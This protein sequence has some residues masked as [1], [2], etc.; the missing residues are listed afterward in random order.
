[1]WNQ[2]DLIAERDKYGA[3]DVKPGLTGLAQIRGRDEL[4]IDVKAALDGEYVKNMSFIYDAKLFFMTILSVLKH[5][6]V[7]EGGTGAIEKEKIMEK[8]V[9]K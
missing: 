6:G 4:P 9:T 3:N 5:D 1:M 7:V 2:Y 8:Q